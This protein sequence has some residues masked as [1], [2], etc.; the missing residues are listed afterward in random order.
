MS[1]Y[2]KTGVNAD[3]DDNDSLLWNDS[4]VRNLP[5]VKFDVAA[6]KSTKHLSPVERQRE[7]ERREKKARRLERE[8]HTLENAQKAIWAKYKGDKNWPFPCWKLAHHSIVEDIKLEDQ[9]K[10]RQM[11]FLWMLN[12][13]ALVWNCLCYF[14]WN[15]W[16]YDNKEERKSKLNGGL[17]VALLAFFYV[18]AGIPLSWLWWYKRYYNTYAGKLNG[19]RLGIRY[20]AIFGIHCIFAGCMATGYDN[21]ASAGLL[22]MLKCIAHV[23][24]LG[25]L[26]LV[27]F[28][29]WVMVA[30]ASVF[31]LRRQHVDYG[32]QIAAKYISDQQAAGRDGYGNDMRDRAVMAVSK[33]GMQ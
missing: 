10:V 3:D 13:V 15:S 8:L 18:C 25:L 7:I 33:G 30:L 28:V 27:A 32:L 17:P 11:Y 24:S 29:L 31:L 20:F 5:D 12:A 16:K 19:G 22:A 14:A 2:D 26:L 23:T 6:G 9:R 21:L 4:A 1:L